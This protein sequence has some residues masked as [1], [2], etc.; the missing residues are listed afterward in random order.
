[1]K[2]TP[3]LLI[4]IAAAQ[5]S[6]AQGGWLSRS[7]VTSND[8]H[9][10]DFNDRNNGTAVGQFGII[11]RTTG[12]GVTWADQTHL[13]E[14]LLGVS[15]VDSSIGTIVGN[16]GTIIRTTDA[17]ATW[18]TQNSGIT[19][20]LTFVHFVDPDH[21]TA[22]GLGGVILHTTNGGDTWNSQVS[23]VFNDLLGVHFVDQNVGTVVG[24]SEILRTTDGGSTWAVQPNPSSIL[25]AVWMT[26]SDNGVIVGD[27]GLV[28]RTTDAGATWE[29]Q[30]SGTAAWLYSLTFADDTTGWAAGNSGTIIRTT[31]GGITWEEQDTPTN[32]SLRGI[33]APDREN[34]F[35]VGLSGTVLYTT[36][37]GVVTSVEDGVVGGDGIGFGL[38]Q[39]YPNPFNPSTRIQYALNRRTTVV[40]KV[41]DLIGREVATLFKGEQEP[42]FHTAEWDA[43]S[44][45][46]GV[47]LYRIETEKAVQVKRMLLLR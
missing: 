4:L 2:L 24:V 33:A 25:Y 1:M 30:T 37:G 13:F 5:S 29:E 3:A 18:T 26:D 42:G 11:L 22:V 10:V 40:L 39:N 28:L 41:Y 38:L 17:G 31:D 32:R 12:G 8:L 45:S 15:F 20:N 14:S 27:F 7:N 9:C 6:F 19:T 16:S 43:S 23:G 44:S 46:G 35:A 36:T 47:Y 21:G 34:G